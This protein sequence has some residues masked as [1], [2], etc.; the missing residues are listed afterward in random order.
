MQNATNR[1]PPTRSALLCWLFSSR[2]LRQC[3]YFCFISLSPNCSFIPYSAAPSAADEYRVS[4]PEPRVEVKWYHQ[5]A[6]TRGVNP[7]PDHAEPFE[8]RGIIYPYAVDRIE[9]RC[10]RCSKSVVYPETK[11]S[12]N[13][14]PRSEE[15]CRRYVRPAAHGR[16][17]IPP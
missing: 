4:H 15:K 3:H 14:K 8:R 6:N 7:R 17:T 10:S 13:S 5:R 1:F 9:R 2:Q 11:R 16:K 12:G